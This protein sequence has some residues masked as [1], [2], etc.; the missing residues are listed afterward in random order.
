MSRAFLIVL[1]SVGCGGAPD[2]ADF[3]DEGANTLLHIAQH[4]ADGLADDGREGPLYLPVMGAMGL[5]ASIKLAGGA[6]PSGLEQT[7]TGLWGAAT[8]IS[9]GKDTPSGH[10]ELSGVPVPWDW[11]YFPPAAPSFPVEIVQAVC[12]ISGAPGILGNCAASGTEIIERLGEEHIRT[13]QPI[14][15][16]STDSVFQIAAHEE[17][18]GL[19]RLLH[20]CQTLAPKLHEMRVGRVIARPFLGSNAENFQRTKNRHD[21]AIEPPE[22]LRDWENQ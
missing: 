10:W 15:Y 16:T 9:I 17:S 7:P 18:F 5:G 2:A 19:D 8:E 20:L 3:G 12:E 4:C 22:D 11:Y 14:C 21:Y 13:G 1:D 6:S